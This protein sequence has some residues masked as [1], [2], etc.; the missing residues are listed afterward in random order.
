MIP[1]RHRAQ[2]LLVSFALTLTASAVS[3]IVF[4]GG[5][6]LEME[7]GRKE[8]RSIPIVAA[9]LYSLL[10]NKSNVDVYVCFADDDRID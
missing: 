2:L 6:K 7:G 10:M 3:C 9:V 4:K 5:R 8:G 1:W